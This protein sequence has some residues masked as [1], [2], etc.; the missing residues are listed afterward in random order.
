VKVAV[1]SDIHSN[2][3]ALDAVLASMGTVDAVWHLGDVVGYGPE[4][5]AV[6]ERLRAIGAIGAIGVR[7]NHDDAVVSAVEP[8]DFVSYAAT[9]VRWTRTRISAI[10]REFLEALPLTLVPDGLDATLVH[11]MPDGPLSSYLQGGRDAADCLSDVPTRHCLVGHT[12]VP[13]AFRESAPGVTRS[14]GP[15][16]D[17]DEI[18]L[19]GARHVLNPGSV[20]QPRDGDPRAAFML[21]DTDRGRVT[22]R[23]V[24][25]DIPAVQA[26]MRRAG[27][28]DWLADRL[29]RG[30]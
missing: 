23:R 13:V 15:R 8:R 14:E 28:P 9:A 22:W 30:Q 21:V 19:A 10:T 17:G 7:G 16:T 24:T 29:G 18:L 12:H 4:P 3:V 27:L 6:V 2:V 26:S 11:G 20:G 5:D 1:L 25:Y